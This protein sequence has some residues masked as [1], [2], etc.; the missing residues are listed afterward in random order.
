VF[1][2]VG[3]KTS[4]SNE[5]VNNMLHE[6]AAFNRGP[7][8]AKF[9]PTVMNLVGNTLPLAV[10]YPLEYASEK[11]YDILTNMQTTKK[12]QNRERKKRNQG[13]KTRGVFLGCLKKR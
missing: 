6:I 1:L 3:H 9:V 8:H 12:K 5:A 2:D 7:R 4:S 13:K 10:V 11:G